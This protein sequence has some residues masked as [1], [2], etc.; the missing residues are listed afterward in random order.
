MIF[1]RNKDSIFKEDYL[2]S[3]TFRELQLLSPEQRE[4]F[5]EPLKPFHVFLGSNKLASQEIVKNLQH[6]DEL[7]IRKKDGTSIKQKHKSALLN[8][9]LN[10]EH[11]E[12]EDGYSKS[13]E[14]Y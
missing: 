5:A 8:E 9:M 2:Y 10:K 14:S 1:H 3:L 13:V 7:I 4:I 11:P 6:Y 12:I